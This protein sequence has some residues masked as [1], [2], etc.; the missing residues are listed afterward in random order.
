MQEIVVQKCLDLNQVMEWRVSE[1]EALVSSK[2]WENGNKKEEK[3]LQ[4]F[5]EI[6]SSIMKTISSGS[7]AIV[8][9]VARR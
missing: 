5:G 7:N 1:A 3:R 4:M 2:A 8:K 6:A 9:T